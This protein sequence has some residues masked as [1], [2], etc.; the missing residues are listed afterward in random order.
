M[1]NKHSVK[2]YIS[3]LG[4]WE[5]IETFPLPL[6]EDILAAHIYNM[7]KGINVIKI[8]YKRQLSRVIKD[9]ESYIVKE[10]RRPGPWWIFRPDANS[11]RNAYKLKSLDIPVPCV[12]GWLRSKDGR[13][14]IIMEDLGHQVLAYILRDLTPNSSE[15]LFFIKQLARL[16]GLLHKKKVIYGDLKLTNV[17]IK[18]NS[19]FLVDMDKIKQRNRI[20]LK[21]RL[22]NLRQIMGSFPQDLTD[23]ELD[24]FLNLYVSMGAQAL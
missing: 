4:K 2:K 6:A 13:G 12:Y 5:I 21:D 11:W 16:V 10:F 20:R 19:L 15:R 24:L 14:F 7:R 8:D 17:M 18:T 23:N 3:S 9:K 1:L 22:Y